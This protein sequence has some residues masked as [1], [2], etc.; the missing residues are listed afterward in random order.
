MVGR[1]RVGATEGTE[2]GYFYVLLG[3]GALVLL[4]FLLS[5]R[6]RF[7][8]RYRLPYV[9]DA[10]L[11]NPSQRAFL[12][13]LER[14]VGRDYR[15]YGR[16]RAVDVI[17][18]RHRPRLDRAG[19][20]R[21]LAPLWDRQFDFLVCAARTGAICCAVNLA[22]R[23]R[24]RR[25]PYRDALDRICA[26]AG[27][28]FVRFVESDDYAAAEIGERLATAMQSRRLPAESVV[29]PPPVKVSDE[30]PEELQ[31]ALHGLAA[32]IG[33]ADRDSRPDPIPAR[34]GL[35][36]SP[37]PLPSA[38]VAPL[39]T[40]IGTRVEPTLV[41]PDDADLDLGPAFSIDDDLD[42]DDQ[43]LRVRRS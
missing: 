22:P 25:G 36:A 34:P 23:S 11:F 9:V 18:L 39:A 5:L 35:A 41:G 2:L 33:G 21:A 15:I 8:R 13:V 37:K 38:T 24:L 26:A 6:K 40:G 3:L 17:G 32:V 29:E 14:A 30:V 27:L 10:I 28:P 42:E 19:R 16:V 43:P 4:A 1:A 12:A 20:R 7:G 31:E